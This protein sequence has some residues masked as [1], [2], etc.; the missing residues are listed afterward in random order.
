MKKISFFKPYR[1]FVAVFGG[2]SLHRTLIGLGFFRAAGRRLCVAS[3]QQRRLLPYLLAGLLFGFSPPFIFGLVLTWN[4]TS[5]F[6]RHVLLLRL[7]FFT[8]SIYPTLISGWAP[9]E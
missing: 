4:Q 3:L 6:T 5:P 1:Q 2:Q 7:H 8:F 9:V